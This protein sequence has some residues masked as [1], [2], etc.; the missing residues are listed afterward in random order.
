MVLRMRQLYGTKPAVA[1]IRPL[2][3]LPESALER[4]I[5]VERCDRDYRRGI[6]KC[7][8]LQVSRTRCNQW[9]REQHKC[10]LARTRDEGTSLTA[11][12]TMD[13]TRARDAARI[14][15]IY[16]ATHDPQCDAGDDYD[17]EENSAYN[18]S[19]EA[20]RQPSCECC[21]IGI[22]YR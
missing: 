15:L 9:S 3:P 6:A 4:R 16:A 20:L 11:E 13:R 17:R 14:G 12:I 19:V 10:L 22:L 21:H 8:L 18:A 1:C 5:D 2:T 7:L